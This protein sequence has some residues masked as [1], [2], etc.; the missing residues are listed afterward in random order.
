VERL[1]N[2]G[3]ELLYLSDNT[4]ERVAYLDQKYSFLQ[5]FDGGIFSH[6][7]KCKKPEPIIYQLVLAKASHPAAACVYIDDKPEYLEPAKSLG[8]QVID[9][10]NAEQLETGL[11][12]LALLK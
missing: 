8:M 10:K 2:G 7:V 11:K 3:F 1:K 12:E 9:F 6:I 4:A 5:K